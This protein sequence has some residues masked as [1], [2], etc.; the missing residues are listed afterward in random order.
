MN[1]SLVNILASRARSKLSYRINF[2][3]VDNSNIDQMNTWCSNNCNG[4]WDY[5]IRYALYW[6]FE[7]EADATMFM[8]RWGSTNGNKLK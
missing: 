2:Q 1:S 8:L 4:I 5:H 7:E 3:E 6:R